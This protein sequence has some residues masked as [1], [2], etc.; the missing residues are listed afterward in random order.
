MNKN[1]VNS[2]LC[3]NKA[4]IFTQNCCGNVCLLQHQFIIRNMCGMMCEMKAKA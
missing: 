3:I 2:Y 4:G 1:S